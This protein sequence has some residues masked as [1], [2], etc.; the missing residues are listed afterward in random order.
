MNM[1][2]LVVLL[3]VNTGIS[4]WN[5]YACGSYL[6][7]S[8]IVGGWAR[9]L[10]WC[11]LIMSACGF[12][13]VYLA[14]VTLVCVSAEWLTVKQAEVMFSLGYLALILPILGSGL[15]IWAQSV[16]EAFRT[17]KFSDVAVASWNTFAQ[18]HNTWDAA[19]SAPSAFKE[20]KEFFSGDFD[21][22]SAK[23]FL[24]IAIVVAVIAGGILT[25]IAIARWADRKVAIDVTGVRGDFA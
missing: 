4:I 2:W 16:I 18:F 22:D 19:S 15:A 23:G 9:F 8:K 24:I 11:G 3:F 20:V 13:W 25:T 17:R 1:F 14:V 5:A 21:G 10:I 6:T 7:E 12:T